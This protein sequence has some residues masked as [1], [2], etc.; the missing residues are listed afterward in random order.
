MMP[1]PFLSLASQPFNNNIRNVFFVFNLSPSK[2]GKYVQFYDF[3][4]VSYKQKHLQ[5]NQQA[6][7]QKQ[8]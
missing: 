7:L 8:C 3:S 2:L 4:F 5:I 1:P 6:T